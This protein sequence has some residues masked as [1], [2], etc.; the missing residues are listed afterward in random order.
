MGNKHYGSYDMTEADA[1]NE[2]QSWVNNGGNVRED[3]PHSGNS[4]DHLHLYDG[5][6]SED[7]V[8]NYK[9]GTGEW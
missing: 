5:N 2:A 8:V 6:K 9:K 4:S 1:R 7:F 3:H